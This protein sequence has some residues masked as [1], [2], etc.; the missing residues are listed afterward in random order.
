[1]ARLLDYPEGLGFTDLQFLSG[2]RAINASATESIAGFI[3][4][5]ASPFGAW[6]FQVTFPP[7]QGVIARRHRGWIVGL[8]GGA[9]ATRFPFP[10]GDRMT[11]AE[12]GITGS[13]ESQPWGNGESWSNG[14]GWRATYPLVALA[15]PA[16]MG[17]SVIELAN[18]F[19]GW[20]LDVGSQIGLSP[21]YFGMHTVTEAI[22]D[23]RYRVWPPLRKAF[24]TDSYA[25]LAPT[26]A[27]R[28]TGLDAAN[29]QRDAQA[30]Q[31]MTATFVEVFDYDVR[32]YFTE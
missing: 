14:K 11:P 24:D 17:D 31:N 18:T 32:D 4:T 2:P 25:T 8:Q 20:Q 29:I 6:S 9:N 26:L 3:Q 23:G 12:A 1:M 5:T 21:L 30:A 13:V 22:G 27:V 10:D 16:A 19:W 15:A 7:L 28:L